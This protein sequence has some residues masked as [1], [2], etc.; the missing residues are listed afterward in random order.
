MLYP[1]ASSA[2]SGVITAPSGPVSDYLWPILAPDGPLLD[3]G[4]CSTGF[5]MVKY[6]PL[7]RSVLSRKWCR[8]SCEQF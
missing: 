7:N 8:K 3:I 5:R 4:W 2:P 6:W 1:E